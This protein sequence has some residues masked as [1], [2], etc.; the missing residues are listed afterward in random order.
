LAHQLHL[1]GGQVEVA[2]AHG[3]GHVQAAGADG[4]LA[5]AAARGGVAVAAQERGAGHAEPLQVDLVADAVAGPGEDQAEPLG[6]GLEVA[7]VVGVLE[8]HLHGVVVHVGHGEVRADPVQAHGLELE[9]GHGAGGV[10][11]EGLVDPDPDLP[12]L[13]V[14]SC[15]EV[16]FED[17]FDEILGHEGSPGGVGHPRQG[18]AR[19]WARLPPRGKP[20]GGLDGAFGGIGGAVVGVPARRGAMTVPRMETPLPS[21]SSGEKRVDKYNDLPVIKIRL[22]A[23]ASLGDDFIG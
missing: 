16:A 17:L 20:V 13:F 6:R 1:G 14:G 12:A 21:A 18:F 2:A 9:V 10:L 22:K 3:H 23:G 4:D 19:A 7:M 15:A 8:A 5:D 11:G